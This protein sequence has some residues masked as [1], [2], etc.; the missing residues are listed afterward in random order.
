MDNYK[1]FFAI[2][3]IDL[4]SYEIAGGIVLVVAATGLEPVTHGQGVGE[5]RKGLSRHDGRADTP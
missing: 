4:I 5:N 3:K 1:L 2:V